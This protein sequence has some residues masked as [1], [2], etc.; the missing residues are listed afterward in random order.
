L[1]HFLD[2]GTEGRF[3]NSQKVL[4][5]TIPKLL[6]PPCKILWHEDVVLAAGLFPCLLPGAWVYC[7][8]HFFPT[9]WIARPLSTVKL[10]RVYQL[11]LL[12]DVLL[13]SLQPA[14][15]LPFEDLPAP[16]LFTSIFCQLWGVTEGGLGLGSDLM[17]EE[18]NNPNDLGEGEE[19]E[20]KEVVEINWPVS[21]L[22]NNLARPPRKPEGAMTVS[23]RL[24]I[25]L[26]EDEVGGGARKEGSVWQFNF[27]RWVWLWGRHKGGGSPHGRGHGHLVCL[28]G[29]IARVRWNGGA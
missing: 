22:A 25:Y 19:V 14:K 13:G 29:D 9:K 8:L 6:D 16:D 28:G 17:L 27:W 12:F 3:L 1:H 23:A 11:P 7:P 10:L 21:Q 4:K 2:G 18:A 5:L 20:G 24:D 15:G 26:V